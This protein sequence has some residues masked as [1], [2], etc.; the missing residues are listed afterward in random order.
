MRVY[1][2]IPTIKAMTF[3]LDDTLYDNRPVIL[4]LESEVY[5]W[6]ARHYPKC[7]LITKD[8]WLTFKYLA[9]V[10]NPNLASD[11]TL[12]RRAQLALGLAHVGYDE[13]DIP[14]I[15]D[16][17]MEQVLHWRHQI[18]I[19]DETHQVLSQLS[20]RMPLVAITNG[21]VYPE[22]IGL[23]QY[24]SL[25][26]KAGPDGEAKPHR[27]MFDKAV[28]FLGLKPS[29]ILHVGDHPVSDVL[30]AK[31]NGFVACWFNDQACNTITSKK[32]RVLPDIEVTRLSYLL[33]I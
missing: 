2:S 1:R 8:D 29:E 28:S 24:F 6:I 18:D 19:P 4:R 21:N 22:R 13:A 27:E 15:I 33:N 17:I 5:Q 32:M 20:K 31:E 23:E 16:K 10:N 14:G 11:V 26:L 7:Q 30:G 25:V 12:L 3:D 9:R